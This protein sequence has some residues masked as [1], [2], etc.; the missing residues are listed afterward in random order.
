MDVD[1]LLKEVIA[2]AKAAGIPVSHA[3]RPH[4]TLNTRAVARFGC[5]A[6]RGETYYI[7]ISA[8]LPAAGERVVR[9][10]LAHE[11]L[12][13]CRGCRNHGDRWKAYAAR[14]SAAY[15][16]QIARTGT[17]EAMGLPNQKP[18]NY[19]LTCQQCGLEIPRTRASALVQHPERYRCRC[20]GLLFLT[21]PPAL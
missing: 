20:G 7:E 9:E 8:R 13:T 18:V 19:L 10:T 5:C 3:I 1:G 17:W 16:Y 6:R 12:H 4:V 21:D 11:V 15:G 14:M 2:Q